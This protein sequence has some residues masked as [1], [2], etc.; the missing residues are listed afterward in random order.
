MLINMPSLINNLPR[1]KIHS[2]HAIKS[3]L[4]S[5]YGELYLYIGRIKFNIINEKFCYN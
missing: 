1:K 4:H 2:D 3:H 5:C